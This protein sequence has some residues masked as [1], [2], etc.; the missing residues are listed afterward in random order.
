LKEGKK[1]LLAFEPKNCNAAGIKNHPSTGSGGGTLNGEAT[2]T[3]NGEAL[4][5][6]N[7]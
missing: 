6:V 3:Q 7:L 5:E 2:V 4:N 1:C